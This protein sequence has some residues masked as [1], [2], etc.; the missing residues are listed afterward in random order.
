M[1]KKRVQVYPL[2]VRFWH[3]SQALVIFALMF[4]GFAIHGNHQLIDF[5][6]AVQIHNVAGLLLV[7]EAFSMF[8]YYI[9]TGRWKQYK[10]LFNI[11]GMIKQARYYA[12]GILKGE[13]HPIHPTEESHLN[14]LQKIT[15][16]L[17]KAVLLP[18]M[19][20]TGTMYLYR[21]YLE[22]NLY[23]RLGIKLFVLNN[24][25]MWHTIGAFLLLAFIIAHVYMTTTGKTIF[26][27]I[28]KMVTGWEE[29]E[30]HSAASD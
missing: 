11:E 29:R 22:E 18:I 8:F 16:F 24:V 9:T 26:S 19:G 13:P 6:T 10:S 2:F 27:H 1:E 3:W 7:A 23:S 17:F 25:A 21:E 15:F 20:I 12:F 4:T 5:N 28:H 14:P 30:E